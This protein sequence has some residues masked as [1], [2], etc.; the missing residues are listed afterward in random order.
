MK[1]ALISVAV[2][3]LLSCGLAQWIQ[4]DFED[5]NANNWVVT[6]GIWAVVSPGAD[7]SV[8]CYGSSSLTSETYNEYFYN[9][10]FEGAV[11]F[12]IDSELY[13]NFD[14]I[15]S[16]QDENNYFMVDLADPDSD[17]PNARIYKYVGGVETILYETP[18]VIEA[19]RWERIEFSIGYSQNIYV[20]FT[21]HSSAYLLVTDSSL[22]CSEVRFR[23][24]AGGKID[25]V[26][27][28]APDKVDEI[29]SIVIPDEFVLHSAYPNPFN[30]VATIPFE[31]KS[32][33]NIS[34]I[35][36][37]ILGKE[38]SH[39]HQ[40]WLQAGSYQATFDGGQ[41][42]SGIYFVRLTAGDFQQTRKMVLMK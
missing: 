37:D 21:G 36:Y 26:Y 14:F 24:Y 30:P 20:V 28:Y 23:F 41:S 12:W 34:L 38:V 27:L 1:A 8:Y 2:L 40:G 15:F 17:D 42:P 9:R 11:D 35:V 5:G 31:L 7:S 29:P 19:G 22:T 4:D 18:N 3:S 39:L 33:S 32:P 6:E 16:Y 10:D 25:N 13:G